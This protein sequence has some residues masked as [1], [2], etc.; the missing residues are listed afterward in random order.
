MQ[1]HK[2]EGKTPS[3]MNTTES[4]V[5]FLLRMIPK[6]EGHSDGVYLA[7]GE[8]KYHD[9]IHFK[10]PSMSLQRAGLTYLIG[11]LL[12]IFAKEKHNP[13][14]FL[15]DLVRIVRKVKVWGCARDFT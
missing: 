15:M 7:L 11:E 13:C 14:I 10:A 6:V 8:L 9:L 3:K 12:V 1:S 5:D 4:G 2:A